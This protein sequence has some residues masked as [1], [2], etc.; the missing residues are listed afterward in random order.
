MHYSM[1]LRILRHARICIDDCCVLLKFS[2][3]YVLIIK[4][5][6]DTTYNFLKIYRDKDQKRILVLLL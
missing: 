6:L 1:P 3:F 2:H 5:P 4:Q